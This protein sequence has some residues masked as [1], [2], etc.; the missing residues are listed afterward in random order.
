MDV[1]EVKML[2]R[3]AIVAVVYV[4]LVLVAWWLG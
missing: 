4:A 1:G 3:I 2:M